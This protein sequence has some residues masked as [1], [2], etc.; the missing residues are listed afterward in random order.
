MHTTLFVRVQRAE[1][2][3]LISVDND[4]PTY[5]QQLAAVENK[6]MSELIA[7][8]NDPSTISFERVDGGDVPAPARKKGSG[9]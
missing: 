1:P 8:G 2:K 3:P 5:E 4:S 6:T 7:G 9:K